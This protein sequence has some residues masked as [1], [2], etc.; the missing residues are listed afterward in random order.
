MRTSLDIKNLSKAYFKNNKPIEVLD[1]FS[2]KVSNGEFVSIV[3]PSGCG[4]T[5]LIN[6]IAGFIKPTSGQIICKKNVGV[7]FQ[8]KL[9]VIFQDRVLYDWLNVKENI[10]FGLKLKK[11]ED[12][13]KIRR[14]ISEMDLKGFESHYPSELS[15]GMQQRVALG[16]AFSVNPGILL[17]DEPFAAVDY[18]TKLKLQRLLLN[19]WEKR[20]PTV[21]YV[22]HDIDEA[23]FLGQR[24]L[25]L[26]NRPSKIVSE[27][28]IDLS[29][30][31]TE[32]TLTQSKFTKIKQKVLHLMHKNNAD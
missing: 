31:R 2:L 22:T 25:V 24:L 8:E 28:E 26:G 10:G 23:I 3:G 14:I 1:N 13:E 21:L 11:K 7:V 15:M 32:K 27:I 20:K 18:L 19:V 29:R 4:K 9:G 30:P 5:T 16:R 12:D 6:C 17:M